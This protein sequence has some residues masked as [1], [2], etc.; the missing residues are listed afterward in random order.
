MTD[1]AELL[2]DGVPEPPALAGLAAAAEARGRRTRGRRRVGLVVAA[3]VLVAAP[4]VV[5]ATVTR[6]ETRPTTPATAPPDLDTSCRVH[7]DGA[8]EGTAD[9]VYVRLCPAGRDLGGTSVAIVADVALTTRLDQAVPLVSDVHLCP[10]APNDGAYTVQI[11]HADGSVS[12]Y[13]SQCPGAYAALMGWIA[14]QE[15]ADL[16]E[17]TFRR[18]ACP[19]L[20]P[21]GSRAPVL[22]E[23][24][25][26][27]PLAFLPVVAAIGCTYDTAGRVTPFPVSADEGEQV[28]LAALSSVVRS[29]LFCAG[30]VTSTSRVVLA[31]A[32][33]SRHE[34]NVRTGACVTSSIDDTE[35]GALPAASALIE[36]LARPS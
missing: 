24:I 20:M 6:D 7:G 5:G 17:I 34:V 30:S 28:R 10:L 9:A 27:N 4:F 3:A 26:S 8:Q 2:R 31:L 29:S 14:E 21:R 13:G 23:D 18:P 33:G 35:Y 32:D 11:G 19:P 25:G 15:A 1:L 12:G 22:R 36:R 16:P